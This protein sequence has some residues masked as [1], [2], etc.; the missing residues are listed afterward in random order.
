MTGQQQ[1]M[2][3][4]KPLVRQKETQNYPAVRRDIIPGSKIQRAEGVCD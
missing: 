4:Y 1:S 3:N 2:Y